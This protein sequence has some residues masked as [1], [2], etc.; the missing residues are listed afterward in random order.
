MRQVYALLSLVWCYV[1]GHVNGACATTLA[2]EML[3]GSATGLPAWPSSKSRHMRTMAPR[4][5]IAKKSTPAKGLDGVLE[6]KRTS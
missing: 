2:A 1:D 3:G 5:F 4:S 6:E